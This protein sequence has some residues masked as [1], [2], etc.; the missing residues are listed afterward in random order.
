MFLLTLKAN[1]SLRFY[2]T[3]AFKVK[4]ATLCKNAKKFLKIFQYSQPTALQG[5]LHPLANIQRE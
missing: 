1:P 5:N 3:Y 2:L 4:G